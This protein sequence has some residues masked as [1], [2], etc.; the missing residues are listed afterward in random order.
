MLV[1]IPGSFI[2]IFKSAMLFTPSVNENAS[3]LSR[4]SK[5]GFAN[6]AMISFNENCA[7]GIK[8]NKKKIKENLE[9]SLML[10]TA[11]NPCIGYEN[12]AKVAKLAHKED[13]TLK[14]AA[15]KLK[16]MTEEEFDKAVIPSNMIRPL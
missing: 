10:V 7:V 4:G 11:L 6:S 2:P 14:E 1:T 5:P 12:A 13:I 15:V 3:N 9:Q 8:A 16:L